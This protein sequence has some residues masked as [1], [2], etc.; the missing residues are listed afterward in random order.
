VRFLQFVKD[1]H[2]AVFYEKKIEI[3]SIDENLKE[4]KKKYIKPYNQPE[5]AS[6]FQVPQAYDGVLNIFFTLP[7]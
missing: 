3:Y 5:G 1:S 6:I 4:A 7:K 2:L